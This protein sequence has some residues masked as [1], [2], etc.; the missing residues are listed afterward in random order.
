MSELL[1]I[2]DECAVPVAACKEALA[3][4]LPPALLIGPSPTPAKAQDVLNARKV[5]ILE[6]LADGLVFILAKMALA[7]QGA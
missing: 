2:E 7:P 1:A 6:A 4:P 3:Y 5:Y